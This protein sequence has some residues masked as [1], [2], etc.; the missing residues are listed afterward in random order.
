MHQ[1]A[2]RSFPLFCCCLTLLHGC[3]YVNLSF[4]VGS[5]TSI[6]SLG[7]SPEGSNPPTTTPQQALSGLRL[8]AVIRGFE[9]STAGLRLRIRAGD[10]EQT[11][12][13]EPFLAGEFRDILT[14]S[15]GEIPL[16]VELI[17]ANGNAVGT[18]E[19]AVN[20]TAERNTDV[21]F[22]INHNPEGPA[23]LALVD[24][25][26]SPITGPTPASS[27][28]PPSNPSNPSTPGTTQSTTSGGGSGDTPSTSTEGFTP[29]ILA[30]GS[31]YI[32][33]IW[34]PPSGPAPVSYI[35]YRNG[36]QVAT[37]DHPVRTT[38]VSN[39]NSGIDYEFKVIAVYADGSQITSETLTTRIT[40]TSG[41]GGGG[42]GG[43][44]SPPSNPAP[45]ITS[46]TASETDLDGTGYPVEITV[47]ATDNTPLT[48]TD[49]TWSCLDC[50][51]GEGQFDTS[52]SPS[53]T[54]NGTTVVWTAPNTPGTYTVQVSVS[55]GVNPP[56][57]QTQTITVN[58]FTADVDVTG[59]YE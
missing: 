19:L 35:I 57:T 6:Q 38:T 54:T 51:D 46:L 56:V 43:G 41:G 15:P 31:G 48:G 4:L 44:S 26:Q 7:S 52:G 2:F 58:S 1:T 8:K 29:R 5:T 28:N 45:V 22:T 23:S 21:T 34:D 49:Y 17:D 40:T 27:N 55:D 10:Q 24:V 53:D 25:S 33:L 42:G 47:T 12:P 14:R 30:S 20:L 9:A 18:L 13:L 37:T 39:L 32:S 11:L 50:P 59:D 3:S 16:R 36:E